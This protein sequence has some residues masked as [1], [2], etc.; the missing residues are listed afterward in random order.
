MRQDS[1]S[2]LWGE[3]EWRE[4]ALEVLCQTSSLFRLCRWLLRQPVQI[5][6]WRYPLLSLRPLR[7][8]P[9]I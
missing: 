5:V 8:P 1:M 2:E 6:L 7:L 3:V 4:E 9:V